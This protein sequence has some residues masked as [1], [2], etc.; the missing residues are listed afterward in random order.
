MVHRLFIVSGNSRLGSASSILCTSAIETS[1]LYS[2]TSPQ[3]RPW[4][5]KKVVVVE[6]RLLWEEV[7]VYHGYVIFKTNDSCTMKRNQNLSINQTETKTNDARYGSFSWPSAIKTRCLYVPFV[8]HC[9]T[10]RHIQRLI[11]PLRRALLAFA[12]VEVKLRVNVRTVRRDRKKWPLKRGGLCYGVE[13]CKTGC[14]LTGVLR[15]KQHW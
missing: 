5:Q 8:S 6:M 14:R 11:W 1:W 7:R 3:W 10:S 12:V 13:K 4:R 2:R 9:S 15:V